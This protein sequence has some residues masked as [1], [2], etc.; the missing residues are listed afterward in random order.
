M[1]HA[2]D[3]RR[4]IVWG[5]VVAIMTTAPLTG[6]LYLAEQAG[7]VPFV[8]FDL[9]DWLARALP[10]D[11]ITGGV[12]VMVDL[13]AELN[14]GETSSTAKTIETLSAVLLFFAVTVALGTVLFIVLSRVSLKTNHPGRFIIGV[15]VGMVIAVP[16][17]LNSIDLNSTQTPDSIIALLLVVSFGVWG[18]VIQWLQERVT[19]LAMVLVAVAPD[20]QAA[21][22]VGV[23]VSATQLTRRDFLIRVGG[24][25]ATLTVIG[26]G[27]GRYLE[28]RDEQEY[29]DLIDR[30]RAAVLP[31]GLPNEGADVEPAPGTR[32]EYT[33]LEDHYRIDINVRA[34]EL[35]AETWRL[36][37]TGEVERALSLSI[38]ELIDGYDAQ[39][40]FVTLAC[41]S[42][43][44]DGDLI[45]TTRW[46][47]VSLR[48]VL[49]DAGIR[50]GATHIKIS[51]VDGFY[52]TVALDLIRGPARDAGLQLGR[53]SAV[54]QAWVPAAYLHSRPIWH[55]TAQ[56]DH[57]H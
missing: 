51:S 43:R 17:I 14:L 8:A 30:R 24:A 41:I 37:V 18:A 19:M 32:P 57:R 23:S 47:G 36:N 53:H 3:F 10:G 54:A 42:N 45:S 31:Q 11:V 26:A 35:D 52:E 13:I 44:V 38:D 46:T 56:V 48:D 9:F 22:T 6:L 16:F 1:G 34:A 4:A 25:S 49:A 27:L 28:Y 12:D 15:L 50:D 29:Q 2:L 33:P 21:P 40:Q 5:V 7:D 39:D 55:E 20:A